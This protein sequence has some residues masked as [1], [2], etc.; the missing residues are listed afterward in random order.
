MIDDK[1]MYKISYGLYLLTTRDSHG[2][3]NGSINNTAVMFT[4]APK[5]L[6]LSVNRGTYTHEILKE[7]GI[8]TLS[9]LTE[10]APFELYKRFGYQS[11]RDINKFEGFEDTARCQNGLI[12]LRKYAN[13]FISGSAIN[14][15]D[16]GTHTLFVA[17]VT[18]SKLINEERSATYEYYF[19]SVKPKDIAPA[20][21]KGY[22]CKICGYIYEGDPL[23][24]DFICPVCKYP[25][26]YFEKL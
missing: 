18:E 1:A 7:S 10:T 14:A 15:Y 17:E 12:Y 25:A 3:D 5:R 22:R 4:V 26:S 9:V 11:G 20:P 23:P 19:A 16:Y 2:R 13:A 24:E 6:S 8:F 21:K